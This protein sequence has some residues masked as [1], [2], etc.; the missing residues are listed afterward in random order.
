M[1]WT[2]LVIKYVLVYTQVIAIYKFLFVFSSALDVKL[3]DDSF[4]DG[5]FEV[6]R[7][8]LKVFWDRLAPYPFWWQGWKLCAFTWHEHQLNTSFVIGM[9]R[10]HLGH[11]DLALKPIM[12]WSF[13]QCNAPTCEAMGNRVTENKKR[14][15]NVCYYYLLS[16]Q[17]NKTMARSSIKF[18][19][20][21]IIFW[22]CFLVW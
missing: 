11:Q 1:H 17:S 19:C 9:L 21:C 15:W 14:V 13:V 8:N 20:K 5:D 22:L 10:S 6:V 18:L 16:Y 12:Q 7:G 2:I 3:K 4:P